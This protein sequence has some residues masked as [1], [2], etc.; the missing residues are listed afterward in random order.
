MLTVNKGSLSP[1]RRRLV[2]VFQEVQFGR[3]EELLLQNGE[4]VSGPRTRLVRTFTFSG[5]SGAKKDPPVDDFALKRQIVELFAYFDRIGTGSIA[6]I[7]IK[8]GLPCLMTIEESLVLPGPRRGARATGCR[9]TS[10]A[11]IPDPRAGTG[12][13]DAPED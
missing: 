5:E 12:A 13:P 8:A 10:G 3:V 7:D 9:Q 2:Y 4:P 6:R 11:A 1:A